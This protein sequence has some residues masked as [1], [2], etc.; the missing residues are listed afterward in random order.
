MTIYERIKK[1]RRDLGLSAEALA[2][3]LNVSR[4]TIYRYESAYIEKLP[5]STL[6]PL[7]KALNV[8]PSYLMGWEDE[9][10]LH[11]T[12]PLT[13]SDIFMVSPTE[14]GL[15]KKYRSLNENGKSTIDTLTDTLYNQQ[16]QNQDKNKFII[17]ARSGGVKEMT[18][19]QQEIA[20]AFV[21]NLEKNKE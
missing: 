6:E 10:I 13:Q 20:E 15:I 3:A 17:A 8:T 18:D 2:K 19:K 14:Q 16:A 5:L 1:R 9:K 7:S 4:A 11:N 12:L 21:R